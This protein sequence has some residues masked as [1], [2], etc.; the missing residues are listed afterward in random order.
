NVTDCWVC[1]SPLMSE[2]WPWKG[3]SLSPLQILKW[4]HSIVTEEN[5]R[6]FGWILASEVIGT[7]CMGRKG[8][9]FNKWVGESPCKRIYMYNGSHFEWWPQEPTWYWSKEDTGDCTE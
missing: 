2:E 4:N 7:E 6:P 5:K 8:K 9:K 1:V 3:M